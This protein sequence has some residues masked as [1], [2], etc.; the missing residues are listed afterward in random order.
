MSQGI[1]PGSFL[2]TQDFVEFYPHDSQLV[3]EMGGPG[4]FFF[5]LGSITHL[6]SINYCFYYYYYFH[7][8]FLLQQ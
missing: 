7:S 2:V 6:L 3:R 5:H 4:Q 1:I 8:F